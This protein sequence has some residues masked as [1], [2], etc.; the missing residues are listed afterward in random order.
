MIEELERRAAAN[1]V[2]A[3]YGVHWKTL[4]EDFSKA[5]IYSVGR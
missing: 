4:G 1:Y 2:A 3:P 5:R